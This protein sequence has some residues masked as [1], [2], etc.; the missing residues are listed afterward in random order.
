MSHAA[1]VSCILIHFLD[2]ALKSFSVT[3]FTT[4]M[5]HYRGEGGA[6]KTHFVFSLFRGWVQLNL[7][8]DIKLLEDLTSYQMMS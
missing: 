1:R 3:C 7:R 5:E 8:T 6:M 4:E 2:I